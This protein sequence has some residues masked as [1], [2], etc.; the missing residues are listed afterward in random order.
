MQSAAEAEKKKPG[1]VQPP[2]T[3]EKKPSTQELPNPF[4][5]QQAPAAAEKKPAPAE[6][7][8]PFLQKPAAIDPNP[9]EDKMRKVPKVAIDMPKPKAP[10]DTA[11][12]ET[13]RN[14]ESP[15]AGEAR[16]TPAKRLHEKF[17][18]LRRRMEEGAAPPEYHRGNPAD[19]PRGP[20]PEEERE[21]P[22]RLDTLSRKG[23]VYGN[24][25]DLEAQAS[26]EAKKKR[27]KPKEGGE[28]A[29]L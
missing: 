15:E 10:G 7:Q 21:P 17:A 5:A 9:Y 11:L 19:R 13:A 23:T 16:I 8:N 22:E 4:L 25:P 24:R 20:K 12:S 26:Q 28:E 1:Q 6:P 14:L 27:E 18:E 2:P 29:T 3:A